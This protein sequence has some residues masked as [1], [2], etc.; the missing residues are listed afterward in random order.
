MKDT[1]YTKKYA[2][3]YANFDILRPDYNIWY[4]GTSHNTIYCVFRRIGHLLR[5][6]PLYPTEL[7]E[8]VI[9]YVL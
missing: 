1:I 5:R 9:V 3:K 8:R 7:H 6:R 2:K 4:R